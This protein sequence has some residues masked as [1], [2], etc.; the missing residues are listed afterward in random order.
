MGKKRLTNVPILST[1]HKV[2][3]TINIGA[4]TDEF[5]SLKI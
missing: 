4:L 2:A 3:N 5:A 1:D